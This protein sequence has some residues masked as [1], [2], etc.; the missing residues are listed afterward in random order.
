MLFQPRAFGVPLRLDA[1][2][3]DAA[4]QAE[5]PT[6]FTAI[7]AKEIAVLMP[8]EIGDRA[9]AVLQK[10]FLHRLA[11]AP[12]QADR[13]WCEKLQRFGFA[14]DRKSLGLVEIRGDL[15]EELVMGKSD[16]DGDADLALHVL[17]K[18]GKDI[19][20]RRAMEAFGAGEVEEGS[21]IEIGSTNGV[22]PSIMARTA[23]PAT[24]Y[25]SMFGLITMACGQASSALN[26]GMA[27][28]TP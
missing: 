18:P 11:D 15:C 24:A 21:S 13:L 8:P 12:D 28:R 4:R 6:T 17:C 25:F 27:E 3:V 2:A 10:P 20:G 23:R 26:I 1:P 9:N 5:Q 7:T 16:R 14:N 22:S 19:G